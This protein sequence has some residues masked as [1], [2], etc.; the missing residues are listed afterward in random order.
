MTNPYDPETDSKDQ[1]L[2]KQL[3]SE[4]TKVTDYRLTTWC[5]VTPKRL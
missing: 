1:K 5:R 2:P 3:E 4:G